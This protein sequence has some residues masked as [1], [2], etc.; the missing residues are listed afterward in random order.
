MRT[1]RVT[2]L[3]T[4]AE[5]AALNARAAALGTS[6]G[7]VLRAGLEDESSLTLE[8]EEEIALLARQLSEAVPKMRASLD[9]SS[10]R[11]EALHEEMEVFFHEKGIG[12]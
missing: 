12:S 11:L 5:K 4:A 2:V 6:S 10:K 3:M 9:R 1:E 8:Q 7:A